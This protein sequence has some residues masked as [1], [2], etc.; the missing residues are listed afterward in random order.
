MMILIGSSVPQIASAAITA[1]TIFQGNN[2]IEGGGQLVN[3]DGGQGI[4]VASGSLTLSNV[5]LTNFATTGGTGSGGGAGFGGAIFI[6][7]GATVT[8]NNVNFTANSAAGG[9]ANFDIKL[10]GKLNNAFSSVTINGN[11][12]A[13][14]ENAS[15]A[16]SYLN[17]G[18]GRD[19]FNAFSGGNATTG[20]GGQGGQGGSGSSG[21]AVTLDNMQAA[22]DIAQAAF[23]TAG[24]TT[25]AG[26][27]TAIAATYAAQAAAASAGVV[28]AGLAA[29]FTALSVSNAS[30][31]AEASGDVTQAVVDAVWE[32]AK[33]VA[34]QTTVFQLGIK[35]YGGSGGAGGDGG[36]GSF[37]FGGGAGGLGGDAG[38]AV[39]ISGALGGSGGDGG[40]GGSG[41]FGGG[42]GGGGN[43]GDP[44]DNGG[45]AVT[46]LSDGSPGSG[47]SAGFG[48]GI[49]SE[50]LGGVGG[51]GGSGFGGAIFIR[52][53][54]TLT[55]TGNAL[56]NSNSVRGGNG[57]EETDD[58]GS[59]EAGG[60]SGSNIFMMKGSTV[61]LNA[62]EGN[63][64]QFDSDPYSSSIADDSTTSI[65]GS[66]IA[67]G[68][69]SEINI[70]SGRVIF[71]GT[72]VYSGR[73]N[74]LG[75][76]LQ[77]QDG[78]GIYFDSNITFNGGVLQS[79][80]DFT[81]FVG[82]Q[83]NRTNWIGDGGF[84]AI[85]GD[86]VVRLSNGQPL[87]WAANSFVPNGN[88]LTFGSSSSDS[89]VYFMNNINLN[90]GN[91]TITVEA[92]DFIP[93]TDEAPSVDA[94]VNHTTIRGVISNGALTVNG[95]GYEGRLNLAAA[96][97]YGDGTTIHNGSLVL[98]KAYNPTTG[99][100]L[101][102]GNLNA[103]GAM[104]VNANGTLD[105][106][107]TGNL[108]IGTLAGEGTVDMGTHTLTLNQNGNT[109]FS[110]SLRD[111]GLFEDD[112]SSITGASLV[113]R[114]TG[115]LTLSGNNTYTSGTDIQVGRVTL[116]GSLQSDEISVANGAILDNA[117]SGLISEAT[118]INRGTVNQGLNQTIAIYESAQG[119]V[120]NGTSTL[121]AESYDL[122]DGS[123]INANLGTG[124]VTANDLMTLT[125]TSDASEFLI[126]SGRTQLSSAERLNNS[127]AVTI[128]SPAELILGGS[129]KIGS[130]FGDGN[131]INTGHRLT[132]DSGSF[133][134]DIEGTGGLTKVSDGTFEVLSA[135]TYSGSTLINEGTLSLNGSGALNPTGIINVA[136]GA[137]FDLSQAGNRT[138]ASLTGDGFVS[139]GS[140]T[141]IIN[142]SGSNEFSGVIRDGGLGGGASGGIT[143]TST[144][145]LTLSGANTYTGITQITSGSVVLTGSL[146]SLFVNVEVGTSL[147]VTASGLAS[148]SAIL[149]DGIINL[150]ADDS[151]FSFT[152]QGTL[153]AS[154]N[155]LTAATY[156]LG[157]G[158]LINANLGT[159]VITAN[160]TV[161]I[162]GTSSG[163]QL[164]VETGTTTLGAAE[165]LDDSMRVTLESVATLVL[166]GSEKIGSLFGEGDLINSGHRLTLDSGSFSG[167]IEGTGGLT[168]VSDGTFE[169]L[170]A[171]TYSGSTLI[172]EGTLELSGNGSLVSDSVTISAG[173][174]LDNLNGGLSSLATVTNNGTLNIA[175]VNDTILILNSNNAEVNGTGTL[176]AT[177]YNLTGG[178]VINANLGTGTVNVSSG[179]TNLNGTSAAE[180]V[181]IAAG[182]T[183]SLGASEILWD[184]ATVNVDGRLNL[185]AGD[186]TIGTLN[187]I[188]GGVVDTGEY[189]LIVQN[190]GSFLGSIITTKLNTTGGSLSINSGGEVTTDNVDLS[191]GSTLVIGNG[192]TVTNDENVVINGGS[193]LSL[194]N[195]GSLK[196]GNAIDV[197]ANGVLNLGTNGYNLEYD[198]LTGLGLVET[199]GISFVNVTGS[200][201]RGSL[202]FT[203]DLV[204]RGTLAPGFSPGVTTIMGNYTEAGT[205]DAEFENT[206]AITGHDQVRVG[207]NVNVD[208][209][210]ADLIFRTFNG[211]EPTQ[212][213]VYQLISD[214]AGNEIFVGGN[215]RDVSFDADGISGAGAP[216]ANAAVVFDLDNGQIVATGLNGANSR[217]ADLG[218]TGNR[219]AAAEAI[220]RV[221]QEQGGG[222]NQIRSARASGEDG[223]FFARQVIDSTS[224][225][226][227]DLAKYSPDYYGSLADFAF[228][229]ERAISQMVRRQTSVTTPDFSA[230]NPKGA[231]AGM[232]ATETDGADSSDISRQDYFAGADI[233]AYEGFQVGFIVSK[234]VGKINANLAESD[235]DG[236]GGSLYAHV[237]LPADLRL[238]GSL[239][240]SGYDHD[241]RRSTVNGVVTA[242]TDVNSSTFTLGIMRSGLKVGSVAIAPYAS[243]TYSHASVD[244]FSEIGAIDALE[245]GGYDS[246]FLTGEL[247]S[248]ATW[249]NKVAGRNLNIEL[250]IGLEQVMLDD[251][252]AM[253]VAVISES[254]IAYSLN[255]EDEAKTR[256]TYGLN[257]SY[258]L[259][260][261]VNVFTGLNGHAA[262]EITNNYS[263]GLRVGF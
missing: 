17:E 252:D 263:L 218:N 222:M 153:N 196:T 55:I 89:E 106:S 242:G 112:S 219:R 100:L 180:I 72:N 241:L 19:G 203:H 133:S 60:A 26:L 163:S 239:G 120:L 260:D 75:G 160:N 104:V 82:T 90:G 213:S 41:G 123:I 207:G 124:K 29:G 126:Q 129:E 167:D 161:R 108:T 134:G 191:G 244:G 6:H 250:N 54:G 51:N 182:S 176:T 204:N 256:L 172:N 175:G 88:R 114:G 7:N 1:G 169:V 64:I 76:V 253:G 154:P 83:S 195:G 38:D 246:S 143:K 61:N 80:G 65:D 103:N 37:G 24:D 149:N 59:G 113:K 229:G 121:T 189:Q 3:G 147:D 81:R 198:S 137:D 142:E 249:S 34:L 36:A 93:E 140:H 128:D 107:E 28:T 16:V 146:E 164:I 39:S 109:E 148:G 136:T 215:F 201:I 46:P 42:G 145:E 116:T 157:D 144:G 67:S 159:G 98:V 14:G 125:G 45:S 224:N 56:F 68:R 43:A 234:S 158:S 174:K 184:S 177:T 168:K 111:G 47:G 131:L 91:Q 231:F 227:S 69:G 187:G 243:V 262:S 9:D 238:F 13:N 190:G 77:A 173:A 183:L 95:S 79:N 217:F 220:F 5:T 245:N 87:T 151:V 44:G 102:T 226:T 206:T 247:G 2:T 179:L 257:L 115:T 181:N 96:N 261:S 141:L 194:D 216:V 188:V 57:Q 221:A 8:L 171:L 74:L 62:G 214:L 49:G 139:L 237:A 71:N 15:P 18:D 165:R 30:L 210:S 53:D 170:S 25:S 185:L 138:T 40:A 193:T 85:G 32:S 259:S 73:T 130:L 233:A 150:S 58:I 211:I 94:N 11:T 110:G 35:G 119:G 117:N 92:N 199:N 4:T 101:S 27:Y 78:E 230:N 255:F 21:S 232:I 12:G 162:N 197:A 22:F 23:E 202:T 86:L 10:G 200:S 205:L 50:G 186:E 33:L 155:T 132:L 240:F 20:F 258:E 66:P 235:V 208:P 105:F 31:A 52:P 209:T 70:M 97:T 48:A 248:A 99:S 228:A 236:I 178:T 135:L 122:R 166:G 156:A 192:S 127:V 254:D 251:N 212:G 225:P 84:A 118:L 152:N 223:G 63:I